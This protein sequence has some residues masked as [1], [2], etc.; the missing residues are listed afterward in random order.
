VYG[1]NV[2]V[3][4]N[5]QY[6]AGINGATLYISNNYG[7][8]GSWSTYSQTFT[9]ISL[10]DTG[11]Y[12][13]GC[14]NNGLMYYSYNFGASWAAI[15][16]VNQAWKAVRI[17]GDGYIIVGVTDSSDKIYIYTTVISGLNIENKN[18]ISC[19]IN[20]AGRFYVAPGYVSVSDVP[21]VL[22]DPT[23]GGQTNIRNFGPTFV[24]QPLY[25]QGVAG[26]VGSNITFRTIDTNGNLGD[27]MFLDSTAMYLYENL[28][29]TGSIVLSGS[30]NYVQ[31][32]DGNRQATSYTGYTNAAGTYTNA[33][34]TVDMYGRITNLTNGS[35]AATPTLSAVL[36]AG[37]NAGNQEMTGISSLTLNSYS[38]PVILGSVSR[39]VQSSDYNN[40]AV[41]PIGMETIVSPRI[42]GKSNNI[43]LTITLNQNYNNTINYIVFPS[44][45]YGFTGSSG[46]YNAQGTA[47]AL[48]NF[49]IYE[50]TTTNF[51]FYCSKATND[52]VNIYITFLVIYNGGGSN[53]PAVY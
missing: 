32:P 28:G 8:S 52:N 45:Y 11:Q 1:N 29:I 53:Y 22:S 36:T 35:G 9:Y 44:V 13:A 25:G 38:A 19:S 26:T 5:G 24:I 46:T 49:I 21:F 27:R 34:I 42:T 41:A 50:R 23:N 31:Y 20:N 51:K 4:G 12:M 18:Q 3:S 39:A 7:S 33:N 2:A 16:S 47:N 15:T 37:N 14:L 43:S 6:M 40:V 17:S 48:N 10:S 30:S